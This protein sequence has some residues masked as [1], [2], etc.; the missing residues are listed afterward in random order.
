MAT[1]NI[2]VTVQPSAEAWERAAIA[3]WLLAGTGTSL[4][5]E[6]ARGG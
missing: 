6:A 3:A 5:Q 4:V 2:S 1:P